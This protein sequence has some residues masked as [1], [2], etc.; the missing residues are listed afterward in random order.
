MNATEKILGLRK[1]RC[2]SK[3]LRSIRESQSLVVVFSFSQ[4][5]VL[6][7]FSLLG[8]VNYITATMVRENS[9][10]NENLSR[11]GKSQGIF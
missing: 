7:H 5:I 8:F 1:F 3:Y 11:S 10:K 4:S 2:H 6:V 9:G